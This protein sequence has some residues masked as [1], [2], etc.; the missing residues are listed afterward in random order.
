MRK[1]FTLKFHVNT[2]FPENV[3]IQ[4]INSLKSNTDEFK[5]PDHCVQ[6][7]MNFAKSYRVVDSKSTGKVEMVLN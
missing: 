6:N 3:N 4:K 5:A 2:Y 1:I 7:I